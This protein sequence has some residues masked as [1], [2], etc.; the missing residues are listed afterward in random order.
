MAEEKLDCIVVGAGIS[1]LSCAR[2]LKRAGLKIRVVEARDRVGGRT[3]SHA[4]KHDIIDLGGQWIGPT[5]NNV[6]ALC[7][8]LGIETFKQFTKGKKVM[9]V[10]DEVRTYSGFIPKMKFRALLEV[11]FKMLKVDG[12]AKKTHNLPLTAIEKKYDEISVADWLKENI[13]HDDTRNAL[14]V[15]TQMVMAAE[16]KDLSFLYFLYY[17]KAGQGIQRLT[18]ADGGAQQDRFVTGA[19]TMSLKMAEELA[20]HI[21]LNQPASKITQDA[22]GVKI[23]AKQTFQAK[24]AVLAA[25]PALLAEI[26][27]EPAMPIERELLHQNMPM[28]SVIKFIIAYKEPFWRQMGFSGEVI[29]TEGPVRAMFDDSSED[30]KQAALV[31]FIIA[32]EAKKFTKRSTEERRDEVVKAVCKI[33]GEQ[34]KGFTEYIDKDWIAEEYSKGCY[35]GIMPPGILSQTAEALRKPVNRIHFAGTE[36]ATKW[37]GYF[38]GAIE[39]GLRAAEE[40]LKAK[41]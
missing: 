11:A 5:Q 32:D 21:E 7:K 13:K 3:L 30:L 1:G 29:F 18:K 31:G 24:R 37:V 17:I 23:T 22:Q 10:G 26:N 27:F 28:G 35:V 41:D 36:T 2:A 25:P 40:I 14:T 8:E 39:A 6:I 33:F 15:A 38:D 9:V 19:Q 4:M 16:P 34:G 12:L 20:G